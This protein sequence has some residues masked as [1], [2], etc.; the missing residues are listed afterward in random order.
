MKATASEKYADQ[1]KVY[2]AVGKSILDNA[3]QG[4]H[5]CLFAYGQTGSGKSY[6]MIGY[7]TNRVLSSLFRVSFRLLATKSSIRLP[8]IRE[9]TLNMK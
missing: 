8:P 4:Y 7:G 9:K 6:S 2:N 1:Q 5:C 3:W